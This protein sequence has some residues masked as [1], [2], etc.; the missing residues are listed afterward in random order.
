[1][2][3]LTLI[4]GLILLL[5]LLYRYVLSPAV[6]SPLAKIPN[7]HFSAPIIP[8]WYWSIKRHGRAGTRAIYAVHQS[9]GPVVRL[10]PD[11][12]SACTPGALRTIYIGG[13]EK[14]TWYQDAFVN[15]GKTNLVSMLD[16]SSHSIQKRMISGVYSKSYVQNSPDLQH[17]A[18]HLIF[19]RFLPIL[20]EVAEK[21]FEMDVLN[22]LQA[23]GMDFMTAY[24]FG[25]DC[26]TDFMRDVNY[27]NC[28]L[29]EYQKTKFQYPE[30]RA[31][32]VVE[33][34]ALS[35]CEAADEF[36]QQQKDKMEKAASQP[37]VYGRLSQSL[38]ESSHV[39]LNPREIMLAA[40]SEMLDQM[41]AG[42]ETSGITLSYLMYELSKRP[43]LQAQLHTELLS[44]DPPLSVSELS[45]SNPD[46]DKSLPSPRS[47]DALPL[48][49]SILEE[50][51]RLYAAA[52]AQQARVTP[53]TPDGVTI[54]GYS[55]IPGGV[56][57]SANAYTLHRNTAV[58]PDPE[59][60]IPRRWIDATPGH[61]EEMKRWFWTFSNGGRMCLGS[62]FATQGMKLVAATIY[63]NFTTEIVDDEGMEQT[64]EF[65][66]GPVGEKLVLRFKRV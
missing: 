24:L 22:F 1:M 15:Y 47:I 56:K 45:D 9:K 52:P 17:A 27:R 40:A 4:T 60:W 7:A 43:L 33:K 18:T 39:K 41:I 54:E 10:A 50:T 58:F 3:S 11:H 16:R 51:L 53:F 31:G 55:H 21:G 14:P 38:R 28:F 64:D 32:G 61:I 44:L 20:N 29:Q 26:G 2:L 42:H 30:E 8:F 63:S 25:L 66:S 46:S 62:H 57:V 35:R 19:H 13:Y 48:L 23:V 12:I 6:L 36:I 59:E 37:V 5:L 34:L 49:D 65:I